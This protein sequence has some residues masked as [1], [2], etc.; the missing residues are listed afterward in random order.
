MLLKI[1]VRKSCEMKGV[2][3]TSF[4]NDGIVQQHIIIMLH[5]VMSHIEY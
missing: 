3:E 2:Y 4:L 5:H 1:E